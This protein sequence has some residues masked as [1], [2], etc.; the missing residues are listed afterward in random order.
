ML[1]LEKIEELKKVSNLA[2]KLED[3]DEVNNGHQID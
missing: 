2:N 3:E 1:L